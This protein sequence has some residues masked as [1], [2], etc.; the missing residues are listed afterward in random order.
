MKS[1]SFLKSYYD[2]CWSMRIKLNKGAAATLL[3]Y[4]NYEVLA[5][6]VI[7]HQIAR[8]T[9]DEESLYRERDDFETWD[10]YMVGVPKR[11]VI[12]HLPEAVVHAEEEI[13]KAFYDQE[14]RESWRG[15]KLWPR[16][17]AYMISRGLLWNS[18]KESEVMK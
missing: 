12:I 11:D 17:Q 18:I 10:M 15:R 5:V 16:F 8:F 9:D 6:E 14:F 3:S 1:Q 4:D 13:F 7:L 2:M